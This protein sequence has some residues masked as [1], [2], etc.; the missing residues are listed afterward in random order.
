MNHLMER[1][2]HRV[3]LH[4]PLRNAIN[5]WVEDQGQKRKYDVLAA[6]EVA[7]PVVLKSGRNMSRPDWSKY[8]GSA[9]RHTP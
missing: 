3:K 1:K 2:G 6:L 4:N 7:N 5:L 9:N 8:S